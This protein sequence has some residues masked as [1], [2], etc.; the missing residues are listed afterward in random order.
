MRIVLSGTGKSMCARVI[1]WA[2]T[3]IYGFVQ[4]EK[5]NGNVCV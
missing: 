1:M 4:Y 3:K 5:I 2:C